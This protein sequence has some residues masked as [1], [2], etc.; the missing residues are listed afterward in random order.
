[1]GNRTVYI[2]DDGKDVRPFLYLSDIIGYYGFG[3][4]YNFDRDDD[5]EYRGVRIRKFVL[6]TK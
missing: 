1:M 3:G 4:L 5:F 2:C 6:K